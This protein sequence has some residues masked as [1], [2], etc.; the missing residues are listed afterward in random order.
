[1]RFGLDRLEVRFGLDWIE[2]S[3]VLFTYSFFHSLSF[4]F[5]SNVGLDVLV[6]FH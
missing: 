3:F 2:N 6:V 4:G 5:S 1:M